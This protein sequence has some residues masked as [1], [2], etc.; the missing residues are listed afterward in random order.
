MSLAL[1]EKQAREIGIGYCLYESNR[2]RRLKTLHGELE[3]E[4]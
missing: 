1:T 3:V 2:Y 4:E